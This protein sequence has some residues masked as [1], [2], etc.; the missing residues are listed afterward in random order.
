MIRTVEFL[1][2]LS[3][4]DVVT[5]YHGI[6]VSRYFLRRY[7]IVGHFLIPRIPMLKCALQTPTTGRDV[8]RSMVSQQVFCV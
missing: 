8:T 7:I 1:Q 6:P 5:K 4:I 3:T 2:N